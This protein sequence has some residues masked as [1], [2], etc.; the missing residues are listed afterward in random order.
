M[1]QADVDAGQ[2]T[3]TAT[4]RGIDTTGM[5]SPVSDPSTVVIPQPA[6]PAVAIDKAATVS[7]VADQQAAKAGDTIAYA[8]QVTDTGNVTL[9]SLAVNDPS[10]GA[11]TCP[12][13]ASPGLAPGAS[14]TCT[15]GETHTVT[16]ADVDAGQV[17]DTATATG[18]DTARGTSPD[19][20]PSRVTILT[21]AAAP[22]V[23]LRKIG[24]VSPAADQKAARVGDTIV[25]SFQVTNTGNVT[26]ASLAVSDPTGGAVR[27]PTL[28]APGLAPGHTVTCTGNTRHVVSQ[29]GREGRP[30]RRHRHRH[31]HRHPGHRDTV[32]RALNCYHPRIAARHRQPRHR[33]P[34][35]PPPRRRPTADH[36]CRTQPSRKR[37]P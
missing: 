28:A 15:A 13:P 11:V 4:A 16:Q 33:R 19:S 32:V 8:Y 12:A 31:W 36:Q 27:C 30:G 1:T 29:V 26:L 10:L 21:A 14:E 3:D 5:G 18:T 24:T 23:S 35:A 37:A 20:A 34:V 2:V 6:N 17:N 7:P 9:A 25:Y 22:A